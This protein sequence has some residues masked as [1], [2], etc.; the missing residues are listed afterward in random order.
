MQTAKHKYNELEIKMYDIRREKDMMQLT[1]EE[2]MKENPK[3]GE[4]EIAS[5][6]R[7]RFEDN[8]REKVEVLEKYM[9]QIQ[10]L[11]AKIVDKDNLFS[12]LQT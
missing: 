2:L 9:Q 8:Q 7:D 5:S 4:G 12:Q 11:E 1:F 3:L 10:Y 6:L